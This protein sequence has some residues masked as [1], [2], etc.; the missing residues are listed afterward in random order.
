[1]KPLIIMMAVLGVFLFTF[2]IALPFM[3]AD[4]NKSRLKA[5]RAR[6][7]SLKKELQNQQKVK[8]VSLRDKLGKKTTTQKVAERIN[9]ARLV[10][11]SA[12]K[13]KLSAAGW[14]GA[15]TPQRFI[16]ARIILPIVMGAYSAWMIYGGPLQE[17][18]TGNMRPFTVFGLCVIGFMLPSLLLKNAVTKRSV[19]LSRQ[20]PDALDLMLVCVEAGLSVEQSFMRITEEIG[21]SIPEISE[22]FALTGAELAFLGDKR[23]AY[24]NMTNRVVNAEFRSLATTLIQSEKYGTPVGSAL[25]IL[26]EEARKTRTNTI[27]KKAASL[28]PKMTVPMILFILPTLFMIVIGP[29]VLTLRK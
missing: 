14:R 9:I 4:S 26:S 13:D 21:E 28:G 3:M 19:A 22:E 24:D 11:M 1:M 20:F 25:R 27:E 8:T 17:K 6:R 15:D 10:D 2:A 23:Q 7:E 12:L 5:V 18:I 29:A 16:L